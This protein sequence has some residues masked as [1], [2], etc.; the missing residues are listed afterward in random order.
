MFSYCFFLLVVLCFRA[1]DFASLFDELRLKHLQSLCRARYG[2]LSARIFRCLLVHH[3]LEETQL[4]ELCTAPR[5]DVRRL[6][7]TMLRAHLV[8]LQDVPRSSDRL[9]QKTF[10]LWGVPRA[11][12]CEQYLESLY[13]SWCNL[14]VRANDEADRAKPV[15]DKVDTARRISE[16]E[17]NKV[18]QWKKNADRMEMALHQL[19]QIIMLFHDF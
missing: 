14:R 15:L 1:P 4:S 7:Y 9:P 5:K 11:S 8:S 13:F 17:K 10:Y 16:Q 19:N 18:Q 3:R 6:L 2:S 12:V